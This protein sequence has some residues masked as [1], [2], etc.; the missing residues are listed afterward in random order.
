MTI[1]DDEKVA[2]D[3]VYHY[4]KKYIALEKILSNKTLRLSPCSYTNDPV[5]YKDSDCRFFR[6]QKLIF[7]KK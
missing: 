5:E 2:E 1:L 7:L 6:L 3:L 4:T